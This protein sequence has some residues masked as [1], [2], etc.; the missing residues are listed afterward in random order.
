MGQCDAEPVL[1]YLHQ[2]QIEWNSNVNHEHPELRMGRGIAYN[3]TLY[4]INRVNTIE[5]TVLLDYDDVDDE[6]DEE[7]QRSVTISI[8]LL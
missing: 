3:G 1:N 2:N 4:I 7:V 6:D 8:S 5:G